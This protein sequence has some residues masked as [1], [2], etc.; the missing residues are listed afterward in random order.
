MGIKDSY[1]KKVTFDTHDGLEYKIDQLTA[2]MGKMAARDNGMNR[3][4]KHQ[5]Y[6]SK[7]RGQSRNFYDT[8]NYDRRN[9][10]NR[11]RLNSGDRRIQCSG[12]NRGRPKYEQNYRRGHFRGNVRKYQ[13]LKDRIEENIGVIIGMKIIVGKE[14]GVGLEKDHFQG[15]LIIDGITEA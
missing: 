3:Q 1:T 10:H 13:I 6:Q 11:Y 4:F 5:I 2:M 14:V 8:H 9:Y 12:Q 7:R 15:I